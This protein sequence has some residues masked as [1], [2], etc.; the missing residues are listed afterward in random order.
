MR[1]FRVLAI[2]TGL[3]VELEISHGESAFKEDKSD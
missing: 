1:V 2:S 3:K